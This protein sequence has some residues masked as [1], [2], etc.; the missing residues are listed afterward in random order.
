MHVT[1]TVAVIVAVVCSGVALAQDVD[2]TSR[3]PFQDRPKHGKGVYVRYDCTRFEGT[4]DGGELFGPGRA[5]FADGRVMEGNF[6]FSRLVGKGVATW[7]D[8][9]RYEGYFFNG[10]SNGP[11]VYTTSD[12]TVFEGKFL[13]GAK[14]QGWG[15]RRSLDGSTLI[16]EFREGEPF[17]D[18][19]LVKPDGSR[20]VVV[21]AY[22]G[23]PPGPAA[24]QKPAGPASLPPPTSQP[25][26]P[27][28]DG[29]KPQESPPSSATN[30]IE[31]LNKTIRNLR[32]IFGR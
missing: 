20:T 28:S 21:F 2:Q 10:R 11:G 12:G 27:A 23:K 13:P 22:G 31:D 4:F 14:L 30:P 19:L 1:A 32:G 9:R 24:A 18:M 17:G 29:Q 6:Q 25:P 16:G 7:P 8:G 5:T 26:A 15:T 3:C